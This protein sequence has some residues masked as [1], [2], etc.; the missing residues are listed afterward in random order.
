MKTFNVIVKGA[1]MV[2]AATTMTVAMT[3]CLGDGDSS[4]AYISGISS[5][6][7]ANSNNAYVAFQSSSAWE[8]KRGSDAL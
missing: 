4:Y 1:K 7:Y 8:L 2:L 5:D 6:C 3:S